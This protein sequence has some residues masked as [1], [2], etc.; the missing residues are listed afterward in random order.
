[1]NYMKQVLLATSYV[2]TSATATT[3]KYLLIVITVLVLVVLVLGRLGSNSKI[4]IS[5]L[6][7]AITIVTYY[8]LLLL[9]LKGIRPG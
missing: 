2:A 7:E 5:R 8:Y 1:M 6:L 9:L 3:S 4:Y